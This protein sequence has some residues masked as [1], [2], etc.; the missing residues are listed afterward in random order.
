MET[1]S[2]NS[3]SVIAT[4]HQKD[5]AAHNLSRTKAI[6]EMTV[7]LHDFSRPIDKGVVQC[8]LSWIPQEEYNSWAER[9]GDCQVI[10]LYKVR[11]EDSKNCLVKIVGQGGS[12]QYAVWSPGCN[13]SPDNFYCSHAN[14]KIFSSFFGFTTADLKAKARALYQEHKKETTHA[15]SSTVNSVPMTISELGGGIVNKVDLC[16][17][18]SIS[19]AC[20]FFSRGRRVRGICI[21]LLA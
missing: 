6:P 10:F 5:G 21:T 18:V 14:P 17:E 8:D 13:G 2:N 1:D 9:G 11:K 15:V 12:S 19:P 4:I 16:V 20:F 3:F 7:N